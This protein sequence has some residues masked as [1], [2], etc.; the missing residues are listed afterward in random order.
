MLYLIAAPYRCFA[1]FSIAKDGPRWSLVS[2]KTSVINDHCSILSF[3]ISIIPGHLK[4]DLTIATPS[5]NILIDTHNDNDDDLERSPAA[6][7]RVS[8]ESTLSTSLI[9]QCSKSQP[10]HRSALIKHTINPDNKPRILPS[11]FPSRSPHR[12][13]PSQQRRNITNTDLPIY[14]HSLL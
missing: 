7:A 14:Q 10:L 13:R 6:Q 2:T 3:R 12:R 8:N 9:R 1:L 11:R 4:K 5:C